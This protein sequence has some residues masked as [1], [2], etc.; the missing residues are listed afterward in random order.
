[1]CKKVIVLL[2]GLFAALWFWGC[3]GNQIII[4]NEQLG[5]R[6]NKEQITD[7]SEQIKEQVQG[8]ALLG[9]TAPYVAV[10]VQL[11]QEIFYILNL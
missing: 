4:N 3:V 2:C 5:I 1:M 9:E 8:G 10:F 7:N 11:R 6:K